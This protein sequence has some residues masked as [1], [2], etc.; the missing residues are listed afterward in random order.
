MTDTN[1]SAV[2]AVLLIPLDI[3]EHTIVAGTSVPVVDSAVGEVAWDDT[4]DWII[5]DEVNHAGWIWEAQKDNTDVAPGTDATTWL[6][7]RPS[8][9]MAA[10]DDRLDTATRAE[11]ELKF[12]LRPGFF[13][14]LGLWGLVG[15]NLKVE[16]YDQ[17]DGEVV[18]GFEMELWEQA[19]GLYELLFM[20][21]KRRTQYYMQNIPLYPDPEVHISITSANDAMCEV[22]LIS[23]GHW[24]TLIGAGT[25]GGTEYD[26]EAELKSYSYL[27]RNDDG[28]V[29]RERRG[30]AN[31]VICQV[32]V[33][34]DEGNHAM[35]LL[36]D[37]Q[38]RPVAFIASGLPRY[39]Y[40]N[41][42]G[43][44]SGSV[45]AAGPN[46]ARVRLRIDGA[47]QEAR[48]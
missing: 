3:T 9:R 16:I 5:D 39:E 31:N 45:A 47:V 18:D 8:N 10:F 1:E 29:T 15:E 4:T 23:I 6:R 24:D 7:V 28:N 30:A 48:N 21:L 33:P 40:L 43:D 34:A 27:R 25:W 35:N 2:N 13:S 41:G 12:V 14:G 11:G 32:I 22:A 36:H 17:P 42:F 20:P 38:G 46:H 26:A 37:V 19:A 44:V